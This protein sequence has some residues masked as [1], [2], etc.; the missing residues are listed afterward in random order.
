MKNSNLFLLIIVIC[1]LFIQC[2]TETQ[3][4]QTI[5]A[6]NTVK[7]AKGFSKK[8]IDHR[9]HAMDALVIAC[10]TRN[11][12]NLLNNK[13]A[14]SKE[15]FDLNRKLR[16]FEKVAYNHPQTGERIERD[17]PKAFLKPWS[18]FTID[19]KRMLESIIISFK[20]NL[21][22][23]NKATNH[24]EKWG[25]KDG[26]KVKEVIAQKGV[27][28]AI[29]KPMHKD[30]VSGLVELRL[31][32]EVSL[33][34]ALENI[35]DIVDKE[36][37]KEIKKLQA[38]GLDKKM[39]VKHFKEI[40]NQWNNQSV[41]KVEVYYLDNTNVAS[42]VLLNDTFDRDR[43]LNTITDTGIQKI[44]INHLDNYKD[45]KDNSGK[46]I[47]AHLMAFSPEGIE[48]MN[49]NIVQLNGGKYHQ[50]IVKVRTYEPK[51]NKFPVGSVGN[52]KGKF[53][54]A[55]KGTNLFFAVYIDAD[56]KRSFETIPLN[57]VIERQKQ[58]LSS[59]PQINQNGNSLL[60]WLSP[61]DVVYVPK[62]GENVIDIDF[63]DIKK[64]TFFDLYKV[65]SFTGN[66]I[67]FVQHTVAT[68]VVNKVEF[69][70]LNKMERALDGKM[71]K[72]SCVKLIVDRIG[73]LKSML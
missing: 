8:R 64:D 45:R 61:N 69:S 29:R 4:S 44:L 55:A 59:V 51:G 35:A 41:A 20:Q 38:S 10:A 25:E 19:A 40:N 39:I 6:E 32:K 54:E 67:F 33:N 30:T 72:D 49:K 66:Q 63:R 23:I 46:E 34:N 9:H 68:S 24:Y 28:W 56:G 21:R 16:A 62:N 53:V 42:R 48:E 58:G 12:I 43:I 57:I 50:P 17:V 65:V 71:I 70:S 14:K 7:Y 27:N 73:Q 31:K 47:A 18:N 36:L 15:R 13:H 60:F 11:H 52:K 5:S 2:K 1:F 26:V 37:K 22:V 3:K